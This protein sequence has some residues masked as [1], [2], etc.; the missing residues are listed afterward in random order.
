M[1]RKNYLSSKSDSGAVDDAIF[2]SLAESYDIVGVEP[3][4]WLCFVPEKLHD[5]T[6]RE[7][8]R[9]MTPFYYKKA[10]ERPRTILD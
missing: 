7:Q 6:P 2:Y 8:I 3:L 9:Q 5:D 10:L 1:G 4:R